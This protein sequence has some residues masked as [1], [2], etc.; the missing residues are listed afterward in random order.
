MSL[1]ARS[2]SVDTA[3]KAEWAGRLLV[4]LQF[5]LLALM[6]WRAW[7]SPSSYDIPAVSLLSGS[8]LLALWAL[9]ANRPGN[10]NI[11]PTPRSGGTL[12]TSGPYRWVRHPMYTSV[13]M[14]AAA[15]AVKSHQSVDAG[16]WLALLAVLLVKSGIE[17]RALMIRFP[18][19]QAYKARTKKFL[20]GPAW[21]CARSSS[22]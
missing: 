5:G 12:V 10:F 13:L 7:V 9:A 6:G 4:M 1:S 8:V 2:P 16:L 17:E 20:P 21:P 18:D 11:R 19:Y 14:A 3:A 15:A 22:R